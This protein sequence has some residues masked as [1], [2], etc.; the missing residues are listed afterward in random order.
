VA[1]AFEELLE[2]VPGASDVSAL[3]IGRRP[4]VEFDIDR[5]AAARYGLSVSGIQKTIAAALGGIDVTT[6][7]SGRERSA[8]RVMYARDYRDQLTDLSRIFVRN[9]QGDMIPVSLVAEIATVTGPASIR[10]V[11]GE[12]VGYVML[13]SQGRDEGGLVD[14]ADRVLREAIEEDNSL[15]RDQRT[16][17]FPDGYYFRWVGNYR[18]QMEARQRFSILIPVCLFLIFLLMYLQFKTLAVPSI[19][20]L[21]AVPL[22][23]A[24]GFLF[25]QVWPFLQD[26]LFNLGIMAT[27]SG[28]PVYITV[29]VIVGFIA[30]L[31]ICVDDG[32]LMATYI[33]QLVDLEKPST[34]QELRAIVISAGR[35][36]IRPAVMTTVTTII[37]LIPVLLASGRGS[38]LSRPMALPVFGGML[39]EFMTMLIVP[40][41]YHWWLERKLRLHGTI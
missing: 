31:G 28:G 3:R 20:F 22:A 2:Q 27:P 12:L 23:V 15:P 1:L 18:N 25:M 5:P 9:P 19:I 32:V 41:V 33:H 35:R 36:R 16:I 26:I 39:I 37:A 10:S 17:D 30:L 7:E 4:Y 34:L 8:V 40:V 24:G 13:N 6:L 29:A 14:E 11:D 21:G 38:E